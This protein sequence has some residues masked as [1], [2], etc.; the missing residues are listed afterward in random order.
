MPDTAPTAGHNAPPA[1]AARVTALIDAANI[2]LRDVKAISSDEQAAR[3]QDF[4]RQIDATAKVIDGERKK[5]KEPYLTGAALVDTSYNA[6][7]RPLQTAKTLL[8]PLRD[9]WLREIRRHQDEE[10]LRTALAAE[11]ARKAAEAVAAKPVQTVQDQLAAEAAEL[12]AKTAAEAAD[13]AQTAK[14]QLHGELSGRASSLRTTWK[15][16]ITDVNMA[17]GYY[18]TTPVGRAALTEAVQM[19]ANTDA[20]HIKA[21]DLGI[22]GVVGKAIEKGV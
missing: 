11:E 4:I 10:R 21:E 9:G 17:V 14:P 15:A 1:N 2:W 3:C 16:E 7:L 19:L 20:R 5:E 13:L 18:L 22:P 8:A 6:M 12:V